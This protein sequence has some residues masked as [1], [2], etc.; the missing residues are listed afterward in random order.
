MNSAARK[1]AFASDYMEG[2]HPAILSRLVETNLD[3][4]PGYGTD[5]ICAAARQKILDACGCPKGEVHFLVGGT[6]TNSLV[7]RSL[8][9]PYQGVI[10]AESGHISVHEAG[11][12][13]AGGHKVLTLNHTFG[14]ISAPAIEELARSYWE[15]ENHEHMV[16]PGM[17]YISQP[18]E[19]GTLYSLEELKAIR[20]ACS[21][22]ALPLYVDGAR[23]AYALACPEN[24]VSLKD[25]ASLCDVF[26]IGGTK[27]GAL[28][29]EAVVIPQKGLIPHFFTLI[30]QQG[31]LLAK[32]WLLGL[33]FDIL[34]TDG[35]YE[36][37]GIPAIAAAGRI[38]EALEQSG[39][40]LCFGSPTNQIFFAADNRQL[41]ILREKAEYSFW[42]KCADGR[43]ILRFATSWATTAE[44]AEALA[45]VLRSISSI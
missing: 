1:L 44:E 27:C 45:D 21:K 39:F 4:N 42:E 38:R 43:T 7:I 14:K 11:A 18:T 29:G 8:L 36:R 13:E 2:A 33:Q 37:I 40:S 17:V 32:G 30:K 16:M 35:L 34:F 25:L 5:I 23:L 22:Y 41:A 6:Q 31:A 24:D 26:Y 3:K 20:Q 12:I 19:F 28:F 9:R 15:D 10:A